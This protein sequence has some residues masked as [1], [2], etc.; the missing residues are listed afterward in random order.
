MTD[1]AY[2]IPVDDTEGTPEPQLPGSGEGDTCIDHDYGGPDELAYKDNCGEGI[3]GAT[4]LAF[5]KA[6]YDA[7]IRDP[8]K[9]VASSATTAGGRWTFQMCICCD[10]DYVLVFEKAG[11]YGPDA[12]PINVP[13]TAQSSSSQSSVSS[14]SSF[15]S[16]SSMGVQ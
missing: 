5:T 2:K 10:Q 15:W 4:I 16:D 3:V 9:A 11:S 14:Q 12:V 7:G 13:C 1:Q 8:A 6:D